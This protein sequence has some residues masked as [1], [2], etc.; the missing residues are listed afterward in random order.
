MIALEIEASAERQVAAALNDAAAVAADDDGV[1]ERGSS[2][3]RDAIGVYDPELWLYRDRTTA[4]LWRYA[5]ISVELGRLPSLLGREFFRSQVSAYSVQT[6]EDTV[7]FVR[8]V[9]RS[10]ESLEA[11]ERFLIA[12][13]ALE[14]YTQE[15]VADSLHCTR[16]TI[17]RRYL[18]ALDD[19]S[20]I[21]L[22]R[23]ILR[24][25]PRKESNSPEACQEGKSGE[26]SVSDSQ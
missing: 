10:L 3:E 22:E 18:E 16:R 23:E 20:A 9:E 4:L 2:R 17:V 5:R 25:L 7:I 6:F 24:S 19:L 26:I 15:D 21:F 8:D 13:L 12:M 14:Q 11:D 1:R